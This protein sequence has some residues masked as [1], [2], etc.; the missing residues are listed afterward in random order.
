MHASPNLPVLSQRPMLPTEH[1]RTFTYVNVSVG[2][3]SAQS[4]QIFGVETPLCLH[5]KDR[6]HGHRKRR[7]SRYSSG[8]GMWYSWSQGAQYASSRAVGCL[9]RFQTLAPGYP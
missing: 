5:A 7:R 6:V 3:Y 8:K 4:W 1:P 9:V 2:S